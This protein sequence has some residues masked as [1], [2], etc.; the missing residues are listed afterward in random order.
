MWEL[1]Q[2]VILRAL[3][4]EVTSRG[5]QHTCIQVA[6]ATVGS[7]TDTQPDHLEWTPEY[8]SRIQMF[9]GLDAAAGMFHLRLVGRVQTRITAADAADRAELVVQDWSR[10]RSIR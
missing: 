9:A 1:P 4:T 3:H 8:R 7:T 2:P 6:C 10:L 5:N